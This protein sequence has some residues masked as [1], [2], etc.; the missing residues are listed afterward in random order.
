MIAGLAYN[1][2]KDV[3]VARTYVTRSYDG[4]AN[5][6][7]KGIQVS[8]VSFTA[9]AKDAAGIVIANFILDSGASYLAKDHR[10]GL[11]LVEYSCR[12]RSRKE[13]HR[14]SAKEHDLHGDRSPGSSGL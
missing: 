6:A 9:P 8:D 7:P 5:H 2:Y 12:R 1:W 11:L 3:L 10:A 4:K 14:I 13:S